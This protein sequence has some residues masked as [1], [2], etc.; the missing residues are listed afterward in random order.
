M[1]GSNYNLCSYWLQYNDNIATYK[2][3]ICSIVCVYVDPKLAVLKLCIGNM[4]KYRN[5]DSKK[6]KKNG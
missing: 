1:L 4:N 5:I 3:N 2:D 6:E